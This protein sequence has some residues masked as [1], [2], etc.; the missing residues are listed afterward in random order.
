MA[1]LLDSDGS[2]TDESLEEVKIHLTADE[3]ET[4]GSERILLPKN[5]STGASNVLTHALTSH[6][7]NVNN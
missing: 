7:T 6:I 3:E 2:L 4:W 5:V 1:I